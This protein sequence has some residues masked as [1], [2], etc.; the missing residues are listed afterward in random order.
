MTTKHN[1]RSLIILTSILLVLSPVYAQSTQGDLL[2]YYDES[3]EPHGITAYNPVTG[4]ELQLPITSEVDST[5]T[6]GD[7]RIAYIQ[8]NDVWVLD[9]LNAPYTPINITQTPNEQETLFDWTPN[10]RLLQYGVKSNPDSDSSILYVYDGTQ[11]FAT[12]YGNGLNRYW[13]KNGWYV[14]SND[15]LTDSRWW[16]VRDENGWRV[17]TSNDNQTDSLSWYVWNG[18]ERMNIELSLPSVSAWHRLH[19]TPNNH[20]F[21]TI[22]YTET[23]YMQPIG[24]TD[25]FYWNGRDIREVENPSQDETFLL[26]GWSND[27]RLTLYTSQDFF[28]RWY[29][30]NGVTFTTDGIPDTTTLTQV[31]NST[32]GISEVEWMPDGRLALVTGGN[33]ESDSLLGHPFSC[34]DPC[35]RQVYLWDQ[36]TLVQVTSNDFMGLLID[37][38]DNGNILIS[39]FDGLRIWGITV[40]DDNLDSIFTTKD[41]GKHVHTFARWSTDGNLAYCRMVDLMV[42]NGQNT[43]QLSNKLFRTSAK[44]LIA[45]SYGITCAVG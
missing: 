23:E 28:D 33:P 38:H 15:T 37:V 36:Q 12:D 43:I 45:Q 20:L 9:V 30:W 26:G 40:F 44:W 22:G 3:R 35:W 24:P 29:I 5:R 41:K 4:E 11:V 13:N 2:L 27:G 25:I 6:S 42:W 7:G 8:D 17:I 34:S 21:I 10:G 32:E 39:D 1:I 16:S 18:I 31:N 14:A 19:W